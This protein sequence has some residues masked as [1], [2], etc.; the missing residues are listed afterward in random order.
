MI[1]YVLKNPKTDNRKDQNI[2]NK[3]FIFVGLTHHIASEFEQDDT[4]HRL[5]SK[6]VWNKS[7]YSYIQEVK[8][9]KLYVKGLFTMHSALHIHMQKG[10]E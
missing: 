5:Y 8:D 10:P 3:W 9:G 6:K 2:S 1:Y 4:D 7:T